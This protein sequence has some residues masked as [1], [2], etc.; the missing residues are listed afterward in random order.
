MYII[1]GATGHVGSAVAQSLLDQGEEV[2]V[3]THDAL[4]KEEWQQKGATVAIADVHDANQLRT[5]FKRGKRLFV[6]NPPAPITTDTAQEERK[7]VQSILAALPDSGIEKIVVESTYGAQP[8]YQMGDLGVLYELEQGLVQTGIPTS[9]VRAAYYMSNWDMALATA[10][11]AGQVHTLYPANFK[12]PMAA[13][14]DLGAVG[15]RLLQESVEKTG[16][17]YVEGP[18][19]YSSADVAAAFA[20]ALGKKVK[21]VETPREAWVSTLQQT[22]FSRP[23]AES[24]AAMTAITL[25]QTYE[26]PDAPM[27][28]TT[29]LQDY[30]SALVAH[31][32]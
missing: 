3:I 21:A 11:Q 5:V 32:K 16:L 14:Q 4:K 27:R 31:S 6:L 25:D 2:T 28:G 1:L 12:L 10:Q 29:T 17:H 23:A 19:R 22:G 24:M 13:P 15:A 9:I 7:S 20:D 26:L 18:E 8:G 30:I